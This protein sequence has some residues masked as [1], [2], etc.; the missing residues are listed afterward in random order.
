MGKIGTAGLP[1]GRGSVRA[2]ILAMRPRTL[3]VSVAPVTVGAAL[4]ARHGRFD[5]AVTGCALAAALFLQ[6]AANLA[7]DADDFERGAD[8]DRR[9]GPLRAAQAGL[10]TAAAV[11][12]GAWVCLALA[13][14]CGAFLV[15][16]GGW[17]ILLA[18][19]AGM[20]CALLY[21]GGPVPLGYLGLGDLLVFVFFGPVA[22][23]GT[24]YVQAGSVSPVVWAASL[25]IGALATAILVVNNVRDIPTDAGAGKRTLPVRFGERFGRWEY[26]AL[27]GG[28]YAAIP[29]LWA[30]GGLSGWIWLTWATLPRAIRL[31]AAMATREGAALNSVLGG[32]VELLVVFSALLA[33]GVLAA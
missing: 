14:I 29:I 25:P 23:A 28:A 7:N 26:L 15:A 5:L 4:A 12:R 22:V 13:A 20:A 21:T 19:L 31:S 30:A 18:G 17:P 2:W 3:G 10:L 33:C 6:I 27:T 24:Y 32:T 11:R 9:T 8:T 1:A 16:R